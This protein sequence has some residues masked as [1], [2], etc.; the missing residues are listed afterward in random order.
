M[1]LE[2][3]EN[4][5]INRSFYLT[6]EDESGKVLAKTQDFKLQFIYDAEPPECGIT[7]DKDTKNV[8]RNIEQAVTFG[9]YKKDTIEANVT[10][11]DT[12]SGVNEMSYLVVN[13]SEDKNHYWELLTTEEDYETALSK[14]KFESRE[15][16]KTSGKENSWTIKNIGKLKGERTRM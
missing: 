12:Q 11:S 16:L 5:D 2:I 14:V 1:G 15:G 6:K 3:K 13:T 10:L 9:F 8:V 7:F 4:N